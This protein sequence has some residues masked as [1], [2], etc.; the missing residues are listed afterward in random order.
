M[1]PEA[2]ATARL[3]PSTLSELGMQLAAA[4]TATRGDGETLLPTP[5][6][7]CAGLLTNN[8]DRHFSPGHLLGVWDILIQCLRQQGAGLVGCVDVSLTHESVS[9][10]YLEMLFSGQVADLA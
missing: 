2:S 5:A 4:Q 8:H 9:A 3:R 6:L 7:S 1:H 10:M